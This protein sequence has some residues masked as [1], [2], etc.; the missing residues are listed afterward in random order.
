MDFKPKKIIKIILPII[1]LLLCCC[2]CLPI[3]LT[4]CGLIDVGGSILDSVEIPDIDLG[5]FEETLSNIIPL[6]LEE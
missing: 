1:V 4:A 5:E 3:T 2:C 6:E